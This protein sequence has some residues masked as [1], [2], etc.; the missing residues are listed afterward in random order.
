M[1]AHPLPSR[2]TQFDIRRIYS[3]LISATVT[4]SLAECSHVVPVV[5]REI[6]RKNRPRVALARELPIILAER[7]FPER[8]GF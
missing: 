6:A 1:T 4:N 2:D 5:A 8:R 7:W 3:S